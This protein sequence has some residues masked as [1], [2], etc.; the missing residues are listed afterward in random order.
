MYMLNFLTTWLCYLSTYQYLSINARFNLENI[1]LKMASSQSVIDFHRMFGYI[2]HE[3][4]YHL[5]QSPR[6]QNP[7]FLFDSI[8]T[9]RRYLRWLVF[10]SSTYCLYA[11]VASILAALIA[12]LNWNWNG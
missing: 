11:F 6:C 5:I 9:S 3:K 4:D 1:L 10:G 7:G 8:S 2:F 12:L